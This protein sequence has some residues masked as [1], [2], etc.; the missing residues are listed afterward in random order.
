[1][2]SL[3]TTFWTK[4]PT[5]WDKI[6]NFSTFVLFT[7]LVAQPVSAQ[8]SEWRGACVGGPNMDVA[9]IQGLECLIANVFTVFLTLLGLAGFVM[10]IIG[11]FYWLIS[12]GNAKHVETA[13]GTMTYAVAG[14]VLAL[15]SFI[16]LKLIA[17][18]TG[19]QTILEFRV[20]R[21]DWG[22][23]GGGP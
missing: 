19:V 22:L 18:F 23:P 16:I 9:T 21:S 4:S 11:S 7:L 6:R 15:S 13:R 1:M 2:R 3:S 8:Q 17:D 12:G 20:P 14:I 10:F 5:I